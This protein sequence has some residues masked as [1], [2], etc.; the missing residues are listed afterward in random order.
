MN[1][2]INR[3]ITHQWLKLANPIPN[4]NPIPNEMDPF[5]APSDGF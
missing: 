4:P 2:P 3:R 5:P 1:A